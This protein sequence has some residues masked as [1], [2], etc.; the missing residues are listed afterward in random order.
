[1]AETY[2][3]KAVLSA[4]DKGFSAAMKNA[5][6]STDALGSKIKSGLSFGILTGV[7]QQAFTTLTNGARELIGEIS[8]SNAAWKTF[9]GNMQMLGKGKKEIAGVKKELQA[10]AE[11]TIYSSS[12]LSLIH[13]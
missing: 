8:A 5:T 9:T 1:M 10:F 4:Y 2:S 12:D 7:G 6:K 3:V 11:Q 13:I